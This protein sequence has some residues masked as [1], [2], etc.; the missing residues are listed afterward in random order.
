M[1]VNIID[2]GYGN[3][4]SVINMLKKVDVEARVCTDSKLIKN[5]SHIILPGVGSF[6]AGIKGLY[7]KGFYDVIQN[8]IKTYQIPV[9]GICLGMQLLFN[10][11]EEGFTSGL[12]IFDNKLEKIDPNNSDQTLKVPHMG[13]NF[14]HFSENSKLGNGFQADSRFYFES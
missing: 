6:D 7:E 8:E 4:G 2:S 10:G 13:W 11:S 1:N 12:G 14:V 3:I 9:L 5:A